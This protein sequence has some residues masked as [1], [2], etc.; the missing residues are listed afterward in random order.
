MLQRQTEGGGSLVRLATP[1]AAEPMARCGYIDPRSQGFGEA[2]VP[3][4]LSYGGARFVYHRILG[5][6]VEGLDEGVL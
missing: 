2:A 4:N 5:A 6:V 1:C 3:Q